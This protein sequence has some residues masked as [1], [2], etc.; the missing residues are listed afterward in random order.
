MTKSDKENSFKD[1]RLTQKVFLLNRII[2]DK[3]ISDNGILVYCYLRAIQRTDINWY[4]ISVNAMDYYFRQTYDIETRDKKKYVDGLNDLEQHGLIRKISGKKYEFEYDLQPLYFEPSKTNKENEM[5]FSVVYSDELS[6]IMQINDTNMKSDGKSSIS[7][8][9][10]LRYFV[11]AVST[12][13]NGQEWSYELPDGTITDGVIGFSSI[14]I[15]ADKSNISKD[16]VMAYNT[17]LENAKLLYIFRAKDL[18][19]NYDRTVTGITNTYGRYRY[20]DYVLQKG[21]EHKA[22]YGYD[23]FKESI[24]HKTKNTQHRKSMGA[25]YYNLV[26]KGKEYDEQTIIDIYV[27]AFEFNEAHSEDDYFADKLKDL[28]FFKKYPFITEDCLKNRKKS[29]RKKSEEFIWGEPDPMGDYSIEEIL[30]MPIKSSIY[31][32]LEIENKDDFY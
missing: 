27:Y 24:K 3:T 22:E 5:W 31:E 17:I 12:F 15:L 30:D 26:E 7:R 14:E 18:I 13:M 28:D 25:K 4:Y 19:V 8:A 20:K 10:V 23:S 2:S 9:K 32:E 11:N 6:A 29:K 21:K 16:S 1:Y